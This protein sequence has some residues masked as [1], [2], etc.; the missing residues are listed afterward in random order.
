VLGDLVLCQ[1]RNG[2]RGENDADVAGG[3]GVTHRLFPFK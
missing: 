1:G 3:E 2:R